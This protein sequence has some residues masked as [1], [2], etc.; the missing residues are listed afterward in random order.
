MRIENVVI[1]ASPLISLFR[2][3]QAQLLT[4][5]FTNI[6]IPEAVWQEV[7]HNAHND[8]ASQGIV[9]ATWIKRVNVNQIPQMI[10]QRNLGQ[11][12]FGTKRGQQNDLHSKRAAKSIWN[13]KRAAK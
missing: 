2:S 10:S 1:D 4:Q 11:N 8:S 5:L 6:W 12:Q 3:Q 9:T 13:E 7:T